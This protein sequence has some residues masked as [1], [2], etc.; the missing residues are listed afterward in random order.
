MLIEG[1]EIAVKRLSKGSKQGME[2]F[3]NEVTLIL[4]VIIG[5]CYTCEILHYSWLLNCV[6]TPYEFD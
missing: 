1:Q 6:M 3:K 2:E 4:L 5:F